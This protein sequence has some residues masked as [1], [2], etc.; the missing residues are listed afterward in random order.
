[1]HDLDNILGMFADRMHNSVV[2]S[3]KETINGKRKNVLLNTHHT[4][5]MPLEYH[6]VSLEHPSHERENI[7]LNGEERI[8]GTLGMTRCT[9]SPL[10]ETCSYLCPIAFG[11]FMYKLHSSFTAKLFSRVPSTA[12]K[13]VERVLKY[14]RSPPYVIVDPFVRFVDLSGL[15]NKDENPSVIIYT[16][17][18]EALAY[19]LS[20]LLVKAANGMP[21]SPRASTVAPTTVEVVGAL[22]GQP[23]LPSALTVGLD[24]SVESSPARNEA[25]ALMYNLFCHAI[26][27]KLTAHLIAAGKNKDRATN[28]PPEDLYIDDVTLLVFRPFT[29]HM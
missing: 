8:F 1:M 25:F 17:G 24:H 11:D 23:L 20:T 26:P 4:G 10:I 21:R 18:L 16:D 3:Y 9:S 15:V 14:S 28:V 27:E 12:M 22:V 2:L 6:R 5:Q 19:T 7:W 29:N 13:S